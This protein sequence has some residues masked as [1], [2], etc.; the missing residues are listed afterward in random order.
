MHEVNTRHIVPCDTVMWFGQDKN[1]YSLHF[2][3]S[4]KTAHLVTFE[5]FTTVVLIRQTI[6]SIL[7]NSTNFIDILWAYK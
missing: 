4:T 7:F 6:Q 3:L 2:Y 5:S 1:F